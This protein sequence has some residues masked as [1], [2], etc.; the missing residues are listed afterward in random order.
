MRNKHAWSGA[1]PYQR[2]QPTDKTTTG[3]S[4]GNSS[5]SRGHAHPTRSWS[6]A[7]PMTH[8]KPTPAGQAIDA[9]PG[10]TSTH[11]ML[12]V[13]SSEAGPTYGPG[14]KMLGTPKSGEKNLSPAVSEQMPVHWSKRGYRMDAPSSESAGNAGKARKRP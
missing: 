8:F 1:T 13:K 3:R 6:G 10:S 7:T 14:A 12:S 2:S 4:E 9:I 5:N 11:P